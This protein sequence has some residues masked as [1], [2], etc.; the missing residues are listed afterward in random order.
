MWEGADLLLCADCVP[1]ALPEFHE[2]LLRGK[3]LAVACPKLDDMR[4]HVE[5]LTR[6]FAGNN[7]RSVT[8]AHMEVPCCWGIVQAVRRALEDSGRRDIPL[9]DVTVALSGTI[10]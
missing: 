4:P 1:F 7:I 5:K 8:V 10:L 2:K 3:S 9:H 6:I